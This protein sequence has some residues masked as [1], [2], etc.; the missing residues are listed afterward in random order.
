MLIPS[1]AKSPDCKK[2]LA[3]YAARYPR[4]AQQ[5]S[6]DGGGQLRSLPAWVP[7]PGD[8]IPSEREFGRSLKIS[9]PSLRTGHWVSRGQGCGE[10]SRD[11][12]LC[13]RW[14]TGFRES[15]S[16]LDGISPRLSNLPGVWARITLEFSLSALAAERGKEE[17]H[18]ALADTVAEMFADLGSPADYLIIAQTS[19]NPILATSWLPSLRRCTISGALILFNLQ[20]VN[21]LHGESRNHS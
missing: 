7:Q 20:V 17:H 5:S 1:C 2:V 13:G 11:W 6:K 3:R 9:R 15:V 14:A 12:N 10:S 16:E 19:G 18:T 21:H 4:F 8:R